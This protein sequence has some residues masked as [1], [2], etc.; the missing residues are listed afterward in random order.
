[1]KLG[2]IFITGITLLGVICATEV[3][4]DVVEDGFTG[5]RIV[6]DTE[7]KKW[8]AWCRIPLIEKNKTWVHPDTPLAVGD[9]KYWIEVL[10]TRMHLIPMDIAYVFERDRFKGDADIFEL[11]VGAAKSLVK[12]ISDLI[13]RLKETGQINV[14]REG[15]K[16]LFTTIGDIDT[17][18]LEALGEEYEV[19][20]GKL[21]GIHDGLVGM[22]QK[23]KRRTLKVFYMEE[24]IKL[25]SNFLKKDMEDERIRFFRRREILHHI[26]AK[27]FKDEIFALRVR[28][29]ISW[30]WFET[31]MP[32][33]ATIN[34][35]AEQYG[36]FL[37]ELDKYGMLDEVTDEIFANMLYDK[38]GC[39]CH[40]ETIELNERLQQRIQEMKELVKKEDPIDS[41]NKELACKLAED[42]FNAGEIRA[43]AMAKELIEEEEKEK[44]NAIKSTLAKLKKDKKELEIDPRKNQKK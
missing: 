26:T 21:K 6:R 23:A 36:Q 39:I 2:L 31:N 43:N 7:K 20:C 1:M 30:D 13:D 44:Q 3:A 25:M 33:F 22:V 38:N 19:Y 34:M 29:A 10:R 17:M 28:Q 14:Q 37:E 16:D 32:N 5:A 15:Q 42:D 40:S 11:F 12:K 35:L 18:L 8:M 24:R 41:G 4:E 9:N 27:F